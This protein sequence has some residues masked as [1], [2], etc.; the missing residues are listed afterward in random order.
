MS[1]LN[2]AET[3]YCSFDIQFIVFCFECAIVSVMQM[4]IRRHQNHV[5][6][7][8]HGF[9][10]VWDLFQLECLQINHKRNQRATIF[11]ICMLYHIMWITMRARNTLGK[12]TPLTVA[13]ISIPQYTSSSFGMFFIE[14]VLRV[15]TSNIFIEMFNLL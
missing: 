7:V 6:P 14:F 13:N 1:C 12:Y 3:C 4:H 5:G 11:L 9:Y 2:M 15:T 10:G 8:P